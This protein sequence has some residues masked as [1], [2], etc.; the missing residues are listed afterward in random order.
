MNSVNV[1]PYNTGLEAILLAIRSKQKKNI[2]IYKNC[3]AQKM[4]CFFF[5]PSKKFS[6]SGKLD[7]LFNLSIGK[8]LF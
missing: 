7:K 2:N 5:H 1:N 8:R 4:N 3:L 6:N